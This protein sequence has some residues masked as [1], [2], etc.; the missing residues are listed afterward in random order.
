[1]CKYDVKRWKYSDLESGCCQYAC[2]EMNNNN[3]DSANS[4]NPS[5]NYVKAQNAVHKNNYTK[6]VAQN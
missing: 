4:L 3:K 1:M 5:I 2:F 6:H